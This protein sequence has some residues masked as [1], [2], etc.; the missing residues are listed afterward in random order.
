MILCSQVFEHVSVFRHIC[1]IGS[2]A[3]ARKFVH[4]ITLNKV[5]RIIALDFIIDCAPELQAQINEERRRLLD[6]GRELSILNRIC[7]NRS[8]AAVK[9]R[10]LSCC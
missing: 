9:K 7:A 1:T 5:V 10:A 3:Q 8:G 2:C 6:A 4:P